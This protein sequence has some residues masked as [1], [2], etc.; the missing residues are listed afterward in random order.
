MIFPLSFSKVQSLVAFPC[1]IFNGRRYLRVA[2]LL[3]HITCLDPLKCRFFLLVR[4]SKP[5]FD[6]VE[7]GEE[8]KQRMDIEE[9]KGM[10]GCFFWLL[11][12]LVPLLSHYYSVTNI[13]RMSKIEPETEHLKPLTHPTL[14]TRPA[15]VAWECWIITCLVER[16][17]GRKEFVYRWGLQYFKR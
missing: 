14:T 1:L 5:T 4:N 16:K 9:E 3:P 10:Q 2:Y 8:R 15:L 7:N 12:T 13:M 17:F 6:R 11:C